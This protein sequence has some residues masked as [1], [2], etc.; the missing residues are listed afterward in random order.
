MNERSFAEAEHFRPMR[1]SD[2]WQAVY[3]HRLSVVLWTIVLL[4]VLAFCVFLIPAQFDSYS[5]L[6]IRLGRG[7]V[8]MDQTATLSP[9]VSLQDSRASQVNSVRE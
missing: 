1:L 8:S 7:A 2:L 5:Q 4:P 6:L 3:R 9:T